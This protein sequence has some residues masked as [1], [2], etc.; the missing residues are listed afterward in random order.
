MADDPRDPIAYRLAIGLLGFAAVAAVVGIAWVCA[1]NRCAG[2]VPNGLWL[3]GAA[4][5]GVFVGALIPFPLPSTRLA[6]TSEK[7][8][9]AVVVV[10]AILLASGIAALAVAA[11]QSDLIEWSVLAALVGSVLL[12]LLI[13]S[14]GRRRC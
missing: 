14:P 12:G 3:M 11:A 5:N 10:R 13:P 9:L 8:V 4:I 6:S 7:F 1:E 2:S